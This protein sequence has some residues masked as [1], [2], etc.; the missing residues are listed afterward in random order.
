MAHRFAIALVALAGLTGAAQAQAIDL[1]LVPGHSVQGVIHS[2]SDLDRYSFFGLA[3]EKLIMVGTAM[4]SPLRPRLRLYAGNDFVG[5]YLAKKNSIVGIG[6]ITES[7]LHTV[8]VTGGVSTS[9]A[10]N[11]RLLTRP[12]KQ[13]LLP[14]VTPGAGGAPTSTVFPAR[15]GSLATLILRPAKGT[16]GGLALWYRTSPEAHW[17]NLSSLLLGKPGK[18]QILLR[19]PLEVDSPNCEFR[20]FHSG[21]GGPEDGSPTAEHTML[22]RLVLAR[23]TGRLTEPGSGFGE[24]THILEGLA[25]RANLHEGSAPFL[26][27]R[28]LTVDVDFRRLVGAV[29]VP[30]NLYLVNEAEILAVNEGVGSAPTAHLIAE[31]TVRNATTHGG[32]YPV[33]ALLPPVGKLMGA[34]DHWRIMGEVDPFGALALKGK[35]KSGLNPD[36]WVTIPVESGLV[37][38]DDHHLQSVGLASTAIALR[39]PVSTEPATLL[40]G[41]PVEARPLSFLEGNVSV[42]RAPTP[43]DDTGVSLRAYLNVPNVGQ[44]NAFAGEFQ[45]QLWDFEGSQDWED[46]T[47]VSVPIGTILH[48]TE[49]L[50][51]RFHARMPD[52]LRDALISNGQPLNAVF[53]LVVAEE[54][55]PFEQEEYIT[56]RDQLDQLGTPILPLLNDNEYS[57][58]VS[59]IPGEVDLGIDF[60]EV[61]V[62]T[63]TSIPT[64]SFPKQFSHTFDR[65]FT[66]PSSGDLGSVIDLPF[67]DGFVDT[68]LK[69][70]HIWK[71]GA[72]GL[73]AGA[74][75]ETGLVGLLSA[76]GFSTFPFASDEDC[77]ACTGIAK[78]QAV[79]SHLIEFPAEVNSLLKIDADPSSV[80]FLFVLEIS[81]LDETVLS[82]N[83]PEDL[84]NPSNFS[85]DKEWEFCWDLS[86]DF[87]FGK[88][89][90]K[91]SG[92]SRSPFASM[93]FKMEFVIELCSG[94]RLKAMGS[95]DVSNFPSSVSA[96]L[97]LGFEN[98]STVTLAIS[99]SLGVLNGVIFAGGEIAITL[100]ENTFTQNNEFVVEATFLPSPSVAATA[101]LVAIN[102]IE[103]GKGEV[104]LFIEVPDSEFRCEPTAGYFPDCGIFDSGG[105]RV[106]ELTLL[107]SPPLF[108]RTVPLANNKVFLVGP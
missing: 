55:Q 46:V 42:I 68:H 61:A 79:P 3:G 8:E 75:T 57:L 47:N 53:T 52:A 96:S 24:P 107:S 54:L 92:P 83:L 4:R 74:V 18:T 106:I 14:P 39:P 44:G 69:V 36:L 94:T 43:L 20:V 1:A 102:E 22:V 31:T 7:V 87:N 26:A 67:E 48:G 100:F 97:G 84:P 64:G 19:Y 38:G 6:D 103:V 66:I 40:D 28:E 101:S 35:V 27:G 65:V 50:T 15:A 5:E 73:I 60:D 25:A 12:S 34:G 85:Y 77:G 9:G 30:L 29:D 11:F 45:L 98:N 95:Q 21:H 32:P 82:V 33:R 62:A 90:K 56:R 51:S 81:V 104:G 89:G 2:P 80:P 16:T 70:P 23:G 105:T 41:T 99:L 76:R 17:V 63:G 88:P 86:Q 13:N 78:G 93:P 71:G 58:T 10:Y 91:K 108:E 49:A 37:G 72:E 59:I